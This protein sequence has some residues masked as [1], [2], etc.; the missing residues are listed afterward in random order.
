MRRGPILAFAVASLG[1]SLCSRRP[2]SSAFAQAADANKTE[3]RQRFDRGLSLFN[4]GDNA[5]ALAEF[6]RAYELV[7]N[8]L[9]LFN[10]GLVYAQMGRPVDAV[11]S[12]DALLAAPGSL[13]ADKLARAKTTRDEQAARIAEVTVTTTVPATIQVD[14]VEVGTTPLAAPLKVA[15]GVHTV[16]ALAT[17]YA[18]A[19]K[20]LT[21]AGGQK[22]GSGPRGTRADAGARGAPRAQDA[23]LPAADVVIDRSTGRQDAARPVADGG[24]PGPGTRSSCGGP[25]TTRRRRT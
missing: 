11:A 21:V 6:K 3:A 15:G 24:A 25:G 20:E 4:D 2:S 1:P 14:N 12:L 18:P 17:G 22:A 8:P 7:P 9:V 19:R 23:H 10:V 5:G 16:G 13:A